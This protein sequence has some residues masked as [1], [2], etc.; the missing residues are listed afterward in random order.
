MLRMLRGL[1]FLSVLLV[2]IILA[3][4][5]YLRLTLPK[6]KGS[7]AMSGLQDTVEVIRDK[8]AVPHIYAKHQD[9]A[10]F[11]LGYVHAQDRLWQMEFQRRVG[12]GRL[13]EVV[14]EATLETDKFLRTLGVYR[15]AEASIEKLNPKTRA[16]LEAYVAGINA[17]IASRESF[18]SPLPPEF[19]VLQHHPEFWTVA[20]VLV[21]AKMIAWDLSGNWDDEV[22]RARMAK[23]LSLQ[24]IAELWPPYPGDAP[25]ALPD[26]S[27]LYEKL[28]FDTLWATSPKP[29]PP[30]AGSNNWVLSG[31]KTTTD[32]PLLANDPHLGLSAPSLWY[33]AHLSAPDLEVIGAT[34]PGTPCVLLG[35]T[36]KIAWGFTNT[37]PDVQDMFIEQVN[38]DNPE[39]YL[40]PE[41]YKDFETRIE[42][43]KIK[44]KESVNIEVRESRHGPIISDAN[45]ASQQAADVTGENYVLSFAWTAL[46]EDDVTLQGAIGLNHAKNWEEFTE[47]LRDFHVPQQNIVYADVEGNIGV[48]SP[49]KI[50]IRKAGDGMMPVPGWTGEYDW[51]GFV[52]FEDLPHAYN[53][54]SGE[55]VTANHKITP[56]GYPYFLGNDWAEPYRIERILDLLGKTEKH[57][58]ETFARIQTDQTS[59]MAQT[60]IP[61]LLE[62]KA[63]TTLEGAA[64]A[65]LQNWDGLMDRNKA[66]PLI[67]SAWYRE[68]ARLLYSDELGATFEDYYGFHPLFVENA[69]ADK[70]NTKWC[71]DTRT[72]AN[73]A[74]EFLETKAFK[75]AIVYLSNTYGDDVTKWQWGNAHYAHSDHAI[76]T[77][78]PLARFFDIKIPNGGDAFTINAA[79]SNIGDE[80]PFK[81]NNAPGYRA[82]Y[83]LSNLE[84]SLFIHTSGQSGNPFSRYYKDFAETWRDGRYIPMMT[85]R[86]NVEQEKIGTL[87]LNP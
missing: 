3:G 58:L 11:A 25:I 2:F 20:D 68:L 49:A 39:Q 54:I 47:A 56:D 26:F 80:E 5:I 31:E 83:D 75:E 61:Y 29:E 62:V 7:L 59:L 63:E 55:V 77:N 48:Y 10:Y 23:T 70:T 76:L 38:P 8:N 32:Q 15:Y 9:D 24:Q 81:Q 37:G 4:I 18:F 64:Q 14:G 60:F 66:A 67:F 28:D 69:L 65:E 36:D 42:A 53:P 13:S 35:R 6:V 82:L 46:R 43:I 51:T 16:I 27:A 78:T 84:A 72:P 73:E 41:G 17:Y 34:L 57:S 21:W 33:F 71:D 22:L 44:G 40:T 19:L 12:A 45:A 1:F 87:V 79:R 52:P 30:G 85:K 74:C 86:E 50:P